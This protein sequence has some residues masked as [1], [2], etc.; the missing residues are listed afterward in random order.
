MTGPTQKDGDPR[1]VQRVR[2]IALGARALTRWYG[3]GWFV[4]TIGCVVLA[5]GFVDYFVR[6]QDDGVRWICFGG[7]CLVT[8]WSGVRFLY[9]AWCYH[10]SDVQA[11]QRIE[12]R[13][14]VLGDLLSSAVAFSAQQ[15]GDAKAGSFELRRTVIAQAEVAT[16]PFDFRT[17]LDQ[18]QTKKALAAAALLIITVCMLSFLDGPSVGLAARRLV[19]PWSDLPWP[20]RHQLEFSVAPER[21]PTGDDFEVELIDAN[22]RLPDQVRIH[23]W[24]DDEDAEAAQTF[25]MQPLGQ[26]VTHRLTNVTRGFYY[27]A[28]GGDDQR[29]PWRELKIVEPPR[30]VSQELRLEPP[31]YTGLAARTA[32]GNFRTFRHTRATLHVRV[33]KRLSRAALVTDTI[34]GETSI[35]LHVD[36]DRLGCAL[37]SEDVPAWEIVKSGSYGFQLVDLEGVEFGARETWEVDAIVDVAPTVLL[38]HPATDQFLTARARLPVDVVVKDDLAIRDVVLHFR[39]SSAGDTEQVVDLWRGPEQVPSETPDPSRARDAGDQREDR[40]EWDL[41]QLPNLAPGE[42]LAFR[43]VA[44]DY[45][46]QEGASG[47]RQITIIS[48]EDCEERL[49]ARQAEI[50][51]QIAEVARIQEQT[52]SQ[53]QSLATQ[54]AARVPGANALLREDVDVLQGAELNQRQ[55][56]QRLG[57]PHDGVAAQVAEI[58]QELEYNRLDTPQTMERLQELRDGV[59]A[60]NENELPRI[61]H[62]MVD[63][64]KHAREF[65]AAGGDSSAPAAAERRNSLVQLLGSISAE[66]EKVVGALEQLLGQLTQWDSFRQLTRELGRLRRD[67]EVVKQ[68]S[69]TLR[70]ATLSKDLQSLSDEDRA[71]LVRLTERQ[72]DLAL[73]FE[74]LQSRMD[75]T[76]QTLEGTDGVAAATLSEALELS[77]REG[78]AGGVRD[79]ARNVEENRLSQAVERQAWVI[80]RLIEIQ[81]ILSNRRRPPAEDTVVTLQELERQVADMRQRQDEIVKT[82]EQGTPLEPATLAATRETETQLGAQAE[83]L[84]GQLRGSANRTAQAAMQR[85]AAAL[86]QAADAAGQQQQDALR[87]QALAAARELNEAGQQVKNSLQAAQ[88]RQRDE[89]LAQLLQ[90]LGA[91]R[92]RQQLL[93]NSTQELGPLLEGRSTTDNDGREVREVRDAQSVLAQDLTRE[94]EPV[95]DIESVSLA[96]QDASAA[97]DNAAQRMQQPDAGALNEILS[98]QQDVLDILSR[99]MQALQEEPPPMA[100]QQAEQPA[101]EGGGQCCG[102]QFPAAQLKLLRAMQEEVNARTAR[103]DQDTSGLGSWTPPRLAEQGALAQRQIRLA[104]ITAKLQADAQSNA[105]KPVEPTPKPDPDKPDPEKPAPDKPDPEQPGPEQPDQGKPEP[106]E[107]V[108]PEPEATKPPTEGIDQQLLEGLPAQPEPKPAAPAEDGQVQ[109]PSPDHPVISPF[110]VGEDIGK[111]PPLRRVESG[112]RAAGWR[113]GQRDPGAVTQ[114]TQRQIVSELTTLIEQQMKQGGGAGKQQASQTP[115]PGDEQSKQGNKSAQSGGGGNTQESTGAGPSDDAAQRAM[116]EIWGHLPERLRQQMQ[117]A[118]AIEFLPQYRQLIEDYYRRLS[119]EQEK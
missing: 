15:V 50:L 94:R 113:L 105:A 34:E 109:P 42:Q 12:R 30:V 93:W 114:E 66:Q 44:S 119:E 91:L 45:Q 23:Y 40:Y 73:R 18:R 52:Q 57:H 100:N 85:A 104:E 110:T 87:Q 67:Q 35:P 11:A 81:D 58:L 62:D 115:K 79:A 71:A 25:D 31:A 29:M 76:R 46:P 27:R 103:L 54:L 90:V 21:L 48:D 49:A 69:E 108:Q 64:L 78:V 72:T 1:I 7:V 22:G 74:A 9:R 6:F 20:R 14:P 88:R 65:L 16:E 43:V 3:I 4:A 96:L 68:Q 70:T 51:A 60:L 59:R 75:A 80:E 102:G 116:G 36:N 106:D 53:T 63:A 89:R 8:A 19:C 37:R 99:I 56:Q 26:R 17:C 92:D 97:A 118:D 112:M 55:V 13:Y 5:L 24:F 38:R 77:R 32:T 86:R 47:S 39:R 33:N 107:P 28:T 84:S 82:T 98:H 83:Q 101:G 10:C 41:M 61:E 117:N 111:Q 95:A 2:Q